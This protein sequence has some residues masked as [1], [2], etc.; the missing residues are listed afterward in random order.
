MRDLWI[1]T[2]RA[3]ERLE[4]GSER[5]CVWK[6]VGLSSGR[7]VYAWLAFA[8]PVNILASKIPLHRRVGNIPLSSP[9]PPQKGGEISG[10]KSITHYNFD[11]KTRLSLIF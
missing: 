1:T 7:M 8:C 6:E 9:L 4:S 2:Y 10:I 3:V 5:C 11:Y